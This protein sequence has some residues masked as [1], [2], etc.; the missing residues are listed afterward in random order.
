MR[1]N[2][3]L[4]RIHPPISKW[5][6]ILALEAIDMYI[7]SIILRHFDLVPFLLFVFINI[8]DTA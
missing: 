7:D 6:K 5:R 3:S 1:E 8:I 4:K 2:S